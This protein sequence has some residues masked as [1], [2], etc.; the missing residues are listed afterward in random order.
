MEQLIN[1]DYNINLTKKLIN[2]NDIKNK[3]RSNFDEIEIKINSVKEQMV[4]N[5]EEA[6]NRKENIDDIIES[7]ETLESTS[8]K[9]NNSTIKLRKEQCWSMWRC[10]IYIIIILLLAIFLVILFSCKFNLKTC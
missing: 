7:T 1:K 10:R 4:D 2:E 5:I 6:L 3:H 9:F 8:L